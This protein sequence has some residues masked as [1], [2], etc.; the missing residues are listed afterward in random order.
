MDPLTI[1]ALVGGG[2][3]LLNGIFGYK[4]QNDTN[5][6]SMQIAKYQN[7]YNTEMWNK[8][9]E[10]N[11]PL[12]T[13]QRLTDAG[14]NPRAYQ[15]IGQFANSATP[16]PAANVDYKSPLGKLAL[17]QQTANTAMQMASTQ[18]SIKESKAREQLALSNADLNES[19]KGLMFT[20]GEL[21]AAKKA[22]TDFQYLRDDEK[23]KIELWLRNISYKDG[24]LVIPENIRGIMNK[25]DLEVL[26]D[27]RER[28]K[29]QYMLNREHEGEAG[30]FLGLNSSPYLGIPQALA[31]MIVKT[32]KSLS[33]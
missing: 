20:Q 31:R 2:A 29:Y 10:Y 15:Q 5:A 21:A 8:Q 25:K 3:S 4:G 19:R 1:S 7:E 9:N 17:F 28:A 18:Q 30:I 11:S 23:R 27:V 33:E 32:I 12:A 26:A 14:I 22:Y 24:E 16:Q 6:A 13:M